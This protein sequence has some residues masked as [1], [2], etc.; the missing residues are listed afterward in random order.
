MNPV[1]LASSSF[2]TRRSARE[3][4]PPNCPT[5][6]SSNVA[7]SHW[8][9]DLP[10]TAA[11][12]PRSASV[13]P[14]SVHHGNAEVR[15]DGRTGWETPGSQVGLGEQVQWEGLAG[16]QI[17]GAARVSARLI[18]DVERRRFLRHLM[19]FFKTMP[20][21]DLD[22]APQDHFQGL[23]LVRSQEGDASLEELGIRLQQK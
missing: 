19:S 17:L 16:A 11:I 14:P 10:P 1:I 22:A 6:I 13:L 7:T 9:G 2:F 20:L 3:F 23:L 4:A 18:T 5:E 21:R 8:A 15:T 12:L